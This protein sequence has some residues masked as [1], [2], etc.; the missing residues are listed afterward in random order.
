MDSVDEFIFVNLQFVF[1]YSDVL[2]ADYGPRGQLNEDQRP[3]I[4]E[5]L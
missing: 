3:T 1:K 4:R 5:I 2:L